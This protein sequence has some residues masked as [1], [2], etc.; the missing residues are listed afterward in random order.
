M[1]LRNKRISSCPTK[2]GLHLA[3]STIHF[4]TWCGQTVGLTQVTFHNSNPPS[5]PFVHLSLLV[6]F[7]WNA[8]IPPFLSTMMKKGW[9]MEHKREETSR[10]VPRG[11]RR[12]LSEFVS[13]EG[14]SFFRLP[15]FLLFNCASTGVHSSL[16]VEQWLH[17]EE[18][19]RDAGHRTS[20]IVQ[21]QAP[22]E[23][24][25][26]RSWNFLLLH[27]IDLVCLRMCCGGGWGGGVLAR[28]VLLST[29]QS[30]V[31]K[32][33]LYRAET[34]AVEESLQGQ[35]HAS[36]SV[37]WAVMDLCRGKLRPVPELIFQK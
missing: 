13:I 25:I 9:A 5:K 18:S 7:H 19:E 16:A 28:C 30:G 8:Q 21:V 23:I 4:L 32:S 31:M 26:S 22:I 24:E 10:S 3:F 27:I 15:S 29:S 37:P 20:Y 6:C 12:R 1:K 36:L 33:K 35:K 17:L 11:S 34:V 14:W 2:R